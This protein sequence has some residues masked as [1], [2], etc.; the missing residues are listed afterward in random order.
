MR[1]NQDQFSPGYFYHVYNRTNNKE[2]L[3]T[4][5]ENYAYFLRKYDKYLSPILT[6]YCYCL[7]GNHFHLLVKVKE[8]EYLI[9]FQKEKIEDNH[10]VVSKQF[11]TF[12]G[13]YSKAF[14]KQEN[15]TGGLFQRPFKR[16]KITN[17]TKFANVIY[18][19]HANPELHKLTDNFREYKWS[20]YQTFLSQ[21]PT[22]IPREE[23]LDWFGGLDYFLRFH[24][25]AH[26][27]RTSSWIIE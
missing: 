27:D 26:D 13:T 16:V 4:R 20:S 9:P 1:K 2:K 10:Q 23:V 18:Y 19:I 22:K 12:F 25:D 7:L 6:T 21:Q 11:A 15:R 17:E 8:K 24:K 3:Y 14:N 5:P